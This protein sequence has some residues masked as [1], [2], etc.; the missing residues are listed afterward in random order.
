M[1]ELLQKLG[2]G[3]RLIASADEKTVLDRV[4]DFEVAFQKLDELKADS[5]KYLDSVFSSRGE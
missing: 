3:E 5:Q 1:V 2:L 4:I